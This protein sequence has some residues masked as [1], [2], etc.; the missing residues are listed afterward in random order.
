MRD[1]KDEQIWVNVVRDGG[2]RRLV[3]GDGGE[4]RGESDRDGSGQGQTEGRM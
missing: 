4:G 2:D 1:S 3:A